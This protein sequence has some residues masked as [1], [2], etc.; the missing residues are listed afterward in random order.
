VNL[1]DKLE[2][3]GLGLVEARG[4]SWLTDGIAAS[5]TELAKLGGS[6]SLDALRQS[7][8]FALTKVERHKAELVRL[9]FQR[10]S[11][12]LGRVAVGQNEHAARILSAYGGG[13]GAWGEADHTVAQQGDRVEQARRDYDR[14]LEIAAD[15][16]SAAAK[17]ALP[18]LLAAVAL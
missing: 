8:E 2:E 11:A 18:F 4:E 5:K 15:I 3:R 6:P 9:G 13:R 12:F 16:G 17:T 7:G 14:A 1:F 10:A